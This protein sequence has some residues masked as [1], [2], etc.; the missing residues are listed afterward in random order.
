MS[1]A[2]AD[3][4]APDDL[5]RLRRPRAAVEDV[6]S[7]PGR[8]LE[9]NVRN[10]M[11]SAFRHDFSTVRIHDD[12]QARATARELG[13][14]A[15]TVGDDVVL[16]DRETATEQ[17][18]RLISHELAHV[19]QQRPRRGAESSGQSTAA[20]EREAGEHER[21]DAV[22]RPPGVRATAPRGVVQRAPQTAGGGTLPYREAMEE[23]A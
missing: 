13:A 22:H 10:R 20:A 17:S 23:I 3:L 5:H 8:P 2:Y 4:L 16:S 9:P 12:D 15:Y 11:E 14:R 1:L 19:V 18:S 6:V 7:S 21:T